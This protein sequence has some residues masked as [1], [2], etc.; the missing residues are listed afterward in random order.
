MQV[1]Q[2]QN[3]PH[4]LRYDLVY[5]EMLVNAGDNFTSL[6]TR[7]ML[8]A[9]ELA[10]ISVSFPDIIVVEQRS[11]ASQASE[12]SSNDGLCPDSKYIRTGPHTA[13]CRNK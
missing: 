1:Q 12:V 8:R 13:R 6:L 2:F 11:S 4:W 7:L 3:Q 10:R 9:M 5:H